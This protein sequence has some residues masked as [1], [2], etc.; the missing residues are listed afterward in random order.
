MDPL[1]RLYET[2]HLDAG[3][4]LVAEHRAQNVQVDALAVRSVAHQKETLLQA[5]VAVQDVPGDLLKQVHACLVTARDL[6][7]KGGPPGR[8]RLRLVV[9]VYLYRAHEGLAVLL[10]L[11]RLEVQHA[12]A[13]VEHVLPVEQFRRHDVRLQQRQHAVQ[14]RSRPPVPQAVRD[15]RLD[16]VVPPAL[17]DAVNVFKETQRLEVFQAL[18]LHNLLGDHILRGATQGLLLHFRQP[19]TREAH[20][21]EKL[22]QIRCVHESRRIEHEP[23]EFVPIRNS[24]PQYLDARLGGGDQIGKLPSVHIIVADILYALRKRS[25]AEVYAIF[26]HK[27]THFALESASRIVGVEAQ[28]HAS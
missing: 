16:L 28:K 10:H 7:Q 22:G 9:V 12:V 27:F 18:L 6:L 5:V 1:K 25:A 14:L 24:M 26:E 19:R 21:L 20:V 17:P 2:A 23:L 4:V 13:E 15:V 3:H 11:A 8:P